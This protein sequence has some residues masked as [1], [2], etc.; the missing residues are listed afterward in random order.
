[1]DV[2]STWPQPSDPTH[3]GR[4]SAPPGATTPTHGQSNLDL[5]TFDFLAGEHERP[6]HDAPPRPNG[7]DQRSVD[8]TSSLSAPSTPFFPQYQQGFFL[9][10]APGPYNAIPYG[11]NPWASSSAVPVSSYST[12]NGATTSTHVSQ[13]SPPP[14]QHQETQQQQHTLSS[15][16]MIV[17]FVLAHS[18]FCAYIHTFSFQSIAHSTGRQFAASPLLQSHHERPVVRRAFSAAQPA[19]PAEPGHRLARPVHARCFPPVSIAAA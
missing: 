18:P 2:Y 13:S 3:D 6:C 19:Q 9:S 17:E 11:S 12:L 5:S 16:H 1:M 15:Q 14:Q 10:G 4:S 7:S 8:S